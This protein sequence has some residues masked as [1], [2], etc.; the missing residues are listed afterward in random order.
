MIR[1]YSFLTEKLFL[2]LK[3]FPR[4]VCE[5]FVS[6]SYTYDFKPKSDLSAFLAGLTIYERPSILKDLKYL[7]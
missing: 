3:N 4:I 7:V 6:R 1:P 5:K 2:T